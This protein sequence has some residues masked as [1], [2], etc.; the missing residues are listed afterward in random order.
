MARIV[1]HEACL[2]LIGLVGFCESQGIIFKEILMHLAMYCP[3]F[4]H[5][6]IWPTWDISSCVYSYGMPVRVWDDT[7]TE[8]YI[9]LDLAKSNFVAL[10]K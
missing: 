8:A 2:V 10:L 5:M 1:L 9:R 3:L 6:H 7:F 4:S